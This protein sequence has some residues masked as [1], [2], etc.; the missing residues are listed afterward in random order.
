M[1]QFKSAIEKTVIAPTVCRWWK[2]AVSGD[3]YSAG[4]LN[5]ALYVVNE[6]P[7]H[8]ELNFLLDV[9]DEIREAQS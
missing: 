8:L 2:R 5:G 7:I 4:C 6:T 9:L 3:E 1:S